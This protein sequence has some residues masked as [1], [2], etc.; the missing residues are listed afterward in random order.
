MTDLLK[1]VWWNVHDF[2]HYDLTHAKGQQ[3]R[4]P[5]SRQAYLE[6]CARVDVALNALFVAEGKPSVLALGETTKIAAEGLRDRLLPGYKLFSLDVKLDE[7]TLQVAILYKSCSLIKFTEA[8]PLVVPATPRGTRPMAML[9]IS[10][11]DS[12]IR[13]YC[14]HWQARIDDSSELIRERLADHLSKEVYAYLTGA[15]RSKRSVMIIGDL[16]EE[17]FGIPFKYLHAHRDRK[18]SLSKKHWADD[19]AERTH[20]YNC[21]WRLLGEKHAHDPNDKAQ[22]HHVAG[23]YFWSAKKTWHGFDQVIVS[24]GLLRENSPCIDETQLTVVNLPEFLENGLPCKFSW[25]KDTAIGLSDHLPILVIIKW[26]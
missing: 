4:W 9:D 2:Y 15:P 23:T 1:M 3:S 5:P 6:K 13:V 18:R 21:S 25:E 24:G 12:V 10:I 19:D 26:S 11:G 20:L 7:P 14:C 8:G 16:N 17:P 22:K